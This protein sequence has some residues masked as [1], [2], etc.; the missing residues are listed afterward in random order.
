MTHKAEQLIARMETYAK[1]PFLI[2]ITHD[3]FGPFRY[4]NAHTSITY[5]GEIYEAAYFT[6]EPPDK[7]GSKIGD[8]QITIS[9][10][11]QFWIEKIRT[12]QIA[13][14]IRFMA[15]IM[16]DDG[17]ISGIEP[18]EAMDFTLRAVRWDETRITWA[19][20]F[21]EA[22]SMVVPGDRA[23]ALKCPGVA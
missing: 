14:H 1:F 11:D 13:A 7:D 17:S 15:V 2:T 12:T 19:M 20:V 3:E 21:D 16:Y 6:L 8:G 9:A 22:M 4:A 10:V 18:M 23:T 5:E